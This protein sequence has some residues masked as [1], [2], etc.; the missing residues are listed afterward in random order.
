M[1]TE[2]VYC[3]NCKWNY[4][5]YDSCTVYNEYSN[6]YRDYTRS[7]KNSDGDCRLYSPKEE[8]NEARQK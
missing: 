8:K 2:K 3:K 7:V 1:N 4:N 5:W 6:T